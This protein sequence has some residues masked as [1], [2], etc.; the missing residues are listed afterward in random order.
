MTSS[1][2]QRERSHPVF[3]PCKPRQGCKGKRRQRSTT[4]SPTVELS[5]PSP[6][7]NGGAASAFIPQHRPPEITDKHNETS[8]LNPQG[9]SQA[10][11]STD[12]TDM[13]QEVKHKYQA[14]SKSSVCKRKA[15]ANCR[16]QFNENP[17]RASMSQSSQEANATQEGGQKIIGTERP[18]ALYNHPLS[19]GET[20]DCKEKTLI[21][22]CSNVPNNKKQDFK[23]GRIPPGFSQSPLT[24]DQPGAESHT[25][26]LFGVDLEQEKLCRDPPYSICNPSILP[27]PPA[28]P[29]LDRVRAFT[30]DSCFSSLM[31][32]QD[33]FSKSEAHRNFNSSVTGATVNLRDNIFTGKKHNFCGVNSN[34]LHG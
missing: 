33:S 14:E 15:R 6:A 23:V 21:E 19:K 32:L 18:P 17:M 29:S 26:L 28:L 31:D 16:V 4:K 27:R 8:D 9:H 20:E 25:E 3:I 24:K 5:N 13:S 7:A 2:S 11:Y 1:P 30:K 34:Y 22:F 12:F 10:E